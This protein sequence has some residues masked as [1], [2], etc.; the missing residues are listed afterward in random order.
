MAT[1]F[2]GGLKNPQIPNPQEISRVTLP[3]LLE[4]RDSHVVGPRVV[5]GGTGVDH[6]ELVS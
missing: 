5:V 6:A 3:K 1:G 4:F 2:E